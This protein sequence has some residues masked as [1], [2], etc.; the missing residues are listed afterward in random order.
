[1]KITKTEVEKYLALVEDLNPLHG[2]V[3]PGQ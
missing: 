2:T 3:V 1:M